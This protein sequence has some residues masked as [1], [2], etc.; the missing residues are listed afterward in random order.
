MVIP[1]TKMNVQVI[2]TERV[3]F[4]FLFCRLYGHYFSNVFSFGLCLSD[5]VL[6]ICKFLLCLLFI[7]EFF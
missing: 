3:K 7:W 2:L 6:Y 4:Y 1:L 5:H